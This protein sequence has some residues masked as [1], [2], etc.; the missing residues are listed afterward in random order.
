MFLQA[1]YGTLKSSSRHYGTLKSSSRQSG[2]YGHRYRGATTGS[3]TLHAILARTDRAD[4]D[5]HCPVP[6]PDA[7]NSCNRPFSS[8]AHAH[9]SPE[10][11]LPYPSML[12]W[13]PAR[14]WSRPT[15]VRDADS[16]RAES[17]RLIQGRHL[18][19]VVGKDDVNTL[20]SVSLCSCSPGLGPTLTVSSPAP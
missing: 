20:T 15:A 7:L 10:A 19:G 5:G 17:P 4:D 1:P 13:Q 3:H 14:G 2:C 6:L 18:A 9:M 12:P 16:G 11:V 8:H